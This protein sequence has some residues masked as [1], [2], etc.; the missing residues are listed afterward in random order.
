MELDKAI[1]ERHSVRNFKRTKAPQAG[2]IETIKYIIVQDK[3]KITQLAEAAQQNFIEQVDFLIVI[4]SDK[5]ALER[6]YYDRAKMYSRQQAGASIQNMLLKITELG[7]ATCWIGAFTD[8]IVKRILHIPD[9]VDI[10]AMLPIGYEM[11]KTKQS[12]KPNLDRV[13]YFDDWKNKFMKP[14]RVVQGFQ[15]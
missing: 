9:D 7:L 6:G 2:N 15:T 8:H 13:I 4:C 11:G 14:K 1:K 12:T 10:E 5:S 3:E